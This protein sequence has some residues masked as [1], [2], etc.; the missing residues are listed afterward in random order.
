MCAL[1]V[2]NSPSS[3][4]PLCLFG[5]PRST[6]TAAAACPSVSWRGGGCQLEAWP[7]PC[8]LGW[9]LR[10]LGLLISCAYVCTPT[11]YCVLATFFGHLQPIHEDMHTSSSRFAPLAISLATT[12]P[13]LDDHTPVA[14]AP[15]RWLTLTLPRYRK[16]SIARPEAAGQ[17]SREVSRAC[18][19]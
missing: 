9:A 18:V 7:C 12:G 13:V 2:V 6:S 15:H 3:L 8:A 16:G 14:L 19:V 10:W 5:L 4:A 17:L 11:R 1:R